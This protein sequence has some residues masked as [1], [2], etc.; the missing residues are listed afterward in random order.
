V[1]V[2]HA[3]ASTFV[4]S[5]GPAGWRVGLITHP[6]FGVVTIPGGHVEGDETPP[7]AALREMREESGLAVRLIPAPAAPLP[8]GMRGV[9]PVVAPPW[10]ILEQ[11]VPADGSLAGPHIHVDFLYV[12]VADDPEPVTTPA[13]PFGW[14]HAADLAGLDMFPDTRLLAAALATR[15][16]EISR[17]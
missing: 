15:M 11:P 7:E 5:Q 9:R 1:T 12:A 14:H 4:F 13:H 10:W 8:D 16:D 6:R 3:T 2:K 17:G